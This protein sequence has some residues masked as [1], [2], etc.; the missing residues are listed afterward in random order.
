MKENQKLQKLVLDGNDLSQNECSKTT[1]R[2]FNSSFKDYISKA[3]LK[4]LFLRNCKL[5]QKSVKAFW[6]GFQHNESLEELNLSYNEITELP[7]FN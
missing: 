7:V 5:E 1:F 4:Q 3:K 2:N 6:E